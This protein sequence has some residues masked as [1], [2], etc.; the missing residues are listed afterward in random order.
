MRRFAQHCGKFVA[1]YRRVVD[2]LGF[3]RNEVQLVEHRNDA[4]EALGRE[5][6]GMHVDVSPLCGIDS[7]SAMRVRA[8]ILLSWPGST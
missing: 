4:M 1:A 5:L 2:A 7:A 6:P 8:T 3:Q